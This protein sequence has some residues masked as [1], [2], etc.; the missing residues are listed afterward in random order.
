MIVTKKKLLVAW[1]IGLSLAVSFVF[2]FYHLIFLKVIPVPNY[3]PLTLNVQSPTLAYDETIAY[4]AKTQEILAGRWFLSDVYL[5]EY[6]N[7]PSP[8]FGEVLPAILTAGLAKISGGV[9]QAF[10]VADFIWPMLTFL[11]LVYFI[12][13][14]CRKIWLATAA[15]ITTMVFFKYF[16]HFPYLPS[17]INKII[18]GFNNGYYSEFIRNFHPQTTFIFFLLF[19]IALWKIRLSKK[20]FKDWRVWF[21]GI[22]L[23]SLFYSYLFFWTF[24]SAWLLI[25]VAKTIIK[26]EWL[27]SKQLITAGLIAFILALPYLFILGKFF[28]SPLS[29]SFLTGIKDFTFPSFFTIGLLTGLF[30]LSRFWVKNKEESW[31]WQ[32]FYLTA[33]SITLLAKPLG[34]HINEAV[35]H[36]IQRV[37]HPLATTFLLILLIKKFRQDKVWISFGVSLIV[38]VYQFQAHWQYFKPLAPSFMLEEDRRQLFNFINQNLPRDSVILTRSLKDNL[39]LSAYTQ[40]HVFIPRQQQTLASD[41]ESLERFLLVNKFLAVPEVNISQMFTFTSENQKLAINHQYDFDN[42]GGIFFYFRKYSNESEN[43]YYDCSVPQ[44]QRQLIVKQYQQINSDLNF[45]R[46]KYRMDYWLIGPNDDPTNFMQMP[47]IWKNQSYK[48]FKL[49]QFPLSY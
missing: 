11:I 42:C 36:W 46:A 39:Y 20:T 38:L 3:S 35:G 1:L 28:L 41:Q 44:E 37:V 7:Q 32:S 45:W 6:Q 12:N 22:S 5:W 26:K 48:L 31:Y 47:L 23:A 17:L 25:I 16:K 15:S 19:G 18:D 43:K 40:I 4:A 14:F 49:S 27:V 30:L 2:G 33:L 21:L 34:F 24:A 9:P 10:I 8:L 29:R 13:L